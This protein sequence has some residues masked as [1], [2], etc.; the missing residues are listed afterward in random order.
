LVRATAIATDH[1]S[2]SYGNKNV[3]HDVSFSIR[4]G[5]FVAIIGHNGAGKSTL[6]KTLFGVVPKTGG[7]ILVDSSEIAK[8]TPGAMIARGV[9]FV[10]QGNR[11]FGEL[12][13]NENLRIGETRDGNA[14]FEIR[15]QSLL[16]KFP[17]F[18]TRLRRTAA[19]LSGGEKQLLALVRALLKAPKVLLLD[20]P[21]LGLSPV[22]A[23]RILDHI[24]ELCL[25][26]EVSILLVEQKVREAM[27][28]AP[29]TIVLRHGRIAFDGPSSAIS[30]DD[31][32]RRV[33]L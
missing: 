33:Y 29:R 9:A 7:R 22:A 30:D 27:R 14:D 3:L 19:S 15:L 17:S 31:A 8:A 24:A 12:T 6:L 5:E 18:R 2:A 25:S 4:R 16:S 1:L 32:L 20:E 26:S 23:K 21:S 11:V 13:V 10:P 28:L